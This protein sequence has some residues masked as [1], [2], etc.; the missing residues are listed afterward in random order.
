MPLTE[1]EK[2]S[3]KRAGF[4]VHSPQSSR[5]ELGIFCASEFSPKFDLIEPFLDGGDC[6][7]TDGR[8]LVRCYGENGALEKREGGRYPNV[9]LLYKELDVT[10]EG[11]PVPV[12]SKPEYLNHEFEINVDDFEFCTIDDFDQVTCATHKMAYQE[13]ELGGLRF[14]YQY[15]WRLGQ[16]PGPVRYWIATGN[17]TTRKN[18]CLYFRFDGGDGFL[19]PLGRSE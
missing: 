5:I 15:V 14:Q 2:S 13:V 16:L 17:D 4:T 18:K 8:V 11:T 9:R 19:M 12:L 10:G 6:F 7:A 1:K 3:F